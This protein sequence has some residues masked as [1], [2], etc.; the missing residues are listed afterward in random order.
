[1]GTALAWVL[2][3]C[4]L[5]GGS[6]W[7]QRVAF[8]NP[9]KSDEAYWVA[10]SQSMQAAARSLGQSLEV[11]Y[12]EREH[13][14]ALAFARALVARA[15]ED[16]PDYVV[17]SNDYGTA[18][19]LL[20]I[21]DGSGIRS[22]MAYS[23]PQGELEQQTG[24]PRER[25]PDWIGS[26]EPRA[27]DAGYLTAKT[28]IAKGR[29]AGA[30]AADGK[31]HLLVIAGDRSTTSSVLRN[32][33]ML[34][35]VNEAG[36]VVIA[37]EVY[38]NWSREKA[39]EQAAWLW[40]RHPDARL[41]WAGNDLMAFGAMSAWEQRGG[42]PG[43]DAWFSGINTSRE[44]MD[45]L[46]SGRLA[47]L[48]GGHFITGAWALVMI[49]DFHRGRDFKDEGLTLERSMFALFTPKSAAV[50]MARFGDNLDQIDFSRYSKARNPRLRR[51]DFGFEQ[52]LR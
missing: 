39:A 50:F 43:K 37:Q 44:A 51:Y 7:A 26:L 19:E 32:E 29:A 13:L 11:F 30:R 36:D 2:G 15:P 24:G 34:R 16:R 10:A 47:A 42:T 23:R 40:Q 17:F 49:H 8:I 6:A 21:F 27:Q 4:L 52:L 41:V 31:L 33:G 3:L 14:R 25:H 45:A 46:R 38:A 20:R 35:A 9:G 1:M 12:A 5:S 28:L 22:F 48:A 18:P